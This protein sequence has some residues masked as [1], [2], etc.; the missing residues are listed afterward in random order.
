M[1][2]GAQEPPPLRVRH[3]N[4]IPKVMFLAAIGE[5]TESFDGS[6]GIWPIQELFMPLRA[7][8]AHPRV[9]GQLQPY[10]RPCTIDGDMFVEMIKDLYIPKIVELGS[11]LLQQKTPGASL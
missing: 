6:V 7:S 11:A 4:H 10:L 2:P 3:K 8:P 5:P 9:N 1:P